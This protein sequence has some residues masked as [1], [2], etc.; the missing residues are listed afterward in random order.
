[1]ISHHIVA[2]FAHAR[3]QS[4]LAQSRH[5]HQVSQGRA[6]GRAPARSSRR[7]SH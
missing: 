6:S 7:P 4:L 2:A 3:Q 1:M 5:D